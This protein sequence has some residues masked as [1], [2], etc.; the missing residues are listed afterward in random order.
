M[1]SILGSVFFSG[2]L[3]TLTRIAIDLTSRR[4][5][6]RCDRTERWNESIECEN[7]CFLARVRSRAI[8]T[9]CVVDFEPSLHL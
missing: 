5:A 8:G 1:S 4:I 6:V 9:F 2:Q 7:L 3:T